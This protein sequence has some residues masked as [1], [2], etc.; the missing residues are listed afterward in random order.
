[1][2]AGT[3]GN[4]GVGVP[5]GVGA[6]ITRPDKPVVV[7]TGDTAFGWHGMELDTAARYKAGVVVIVSNNAAVAGLRGKEAPGRHLLH[8]DYHKMCEGLGGWGAKVED[9]S[10]IQPAIREALRV[11]DAKHVPALVNV[12]TDPYAWTEQRKFI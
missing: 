12:I 9:P 3:T 11:A 2:N 7:V 10:E 1:M 4:M 6:K 8:S 5:F